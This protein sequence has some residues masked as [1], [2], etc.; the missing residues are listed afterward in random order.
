MLT[1]IISPQI[2]KI[3]FFS[4]QK[5][6]I[7]F[8]FH[9]NIQICERATTKSPAKFVIIILNNATLNDEVDKCHKNLMENFPGL[10]LL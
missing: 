6:Q 4:W 7:F 10:S 1:Q 8:A 5:S 9:A 2:I 3:V